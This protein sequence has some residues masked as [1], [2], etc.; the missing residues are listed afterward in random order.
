[1]D[2]IKTLD[3]SLKGKY[4]YFSEETKQDKKYYILICD[5]IEENIIY[6]KKLY[7]LYVPKNI[8]IK[9]I[10]TDKIKKDDDI[11][12]IQTHYQCS[13]SVAIEYLEIIS[14]DDFANLKRL[15]KYGSIKGNR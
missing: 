5:Y 13:R 7:Y 14:D 3:N 10:K 4:L 6:S 11:E 2:K 15:Y 12:L 1:M 9:W 8:S